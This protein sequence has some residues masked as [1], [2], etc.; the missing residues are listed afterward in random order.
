MNRID[1][2]KLTTVLP[3]LTNDQGSTFRHIY[4][5]RA[6]FCSIFDSSFF[7]TQRY[8]LCILKCNDLKLAQLALSHILDNTL[9]SKAKFPYFL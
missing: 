5:S 6:I 9:R 8:L 1:V 4:R 3:C 2:L 7:S